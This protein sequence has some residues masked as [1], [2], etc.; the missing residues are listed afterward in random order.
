MELYFFFFLSQ[1]W[2]NIL[3]W[4]PGG[5]KVR[6]RPV[7]QCTF[8]RRS[9]RSA[10]G[11]IWETSF[12]P[13]ISFFFFLLPFLLPV[14][15]LNLSPHTPLLHMPFMP[16]VSNR[17][18]LPGVQIGQKTQR[19]VCFNKVMP[20]LTRQLYNMHVRAKTWAP[21]YRPPPSR[22]GENTVLWG[23][24]PPWYIRKK[25]PFNFT[26]LVLL[27]ALGFGGGGLWIYLSGITQ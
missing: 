1:T 17:W 11:Q 23:H 26:N 20:T 8:H 2:E 16:V 13:E 25:K 15:P 7:S 9:N 5:M 19:L 12:W 22:V 24:L 3:L 21:R 4:Y 27:L 10:A 14:S 18:R 6:S